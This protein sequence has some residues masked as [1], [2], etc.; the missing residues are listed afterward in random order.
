M[1]P[2]CRLSRCT[3]RP[4]PRRGTVARST[5]RQTIAGVVAAVT[6]TF[7]CLLTRLARVLFLRNPTCQRHIPL[8]H[9]ALLNLCSNVEAT[10][11]LRTHITASFSVPVGH[12]RI[13]VGGDPIASNRRIDELYKQGESLVACRRAELRTRTFS[14]MPKLSTSLRACGRNA[15]RRRLISFQIAFTC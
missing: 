6:Q 3:C 15:A 14:G 12:V 7:Q 1:A 4:L 11:L 9:R 5:T 10:R 13:T 8:T 2:G